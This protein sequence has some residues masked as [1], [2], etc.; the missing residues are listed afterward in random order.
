MC[1]GVD[2]MLCLFSDVF[3]DHQEDVR[4]SIMATHTPRPDAACD[5]QKVFHGG[6]GT[7]PPH[8]VEMKKQNGSESDKDTQARERGDQWIR[9]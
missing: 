3:L 6:A 5:A 7:D 9:F 8:N 1:F 4:S 2:N